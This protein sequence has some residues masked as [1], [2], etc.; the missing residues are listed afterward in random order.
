MM[1]HLGLLALLSA[2]HVHVLS[3]LYTQSSSPVLSG[4]MQ[5]QDPVNTFAVH[6]SGDVH[7]PGAALPL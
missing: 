1:K 3:A 6:A 7:G 5:G 2:W 4:N